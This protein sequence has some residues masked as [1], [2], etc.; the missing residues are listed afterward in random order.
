MKVW[1]VGCVLLF[2]LVEFYQWAKGFILPL[3]IYIFAGALLSIASN[4]SQ[5]MSNLFA[6]NEQV[7]QTAS[8]SDIPNILTGETPVQILEEAAAEDGKKLSN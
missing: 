3:P 5:D 6:R 2:L 1:V 4:Y 7:Y 8:L